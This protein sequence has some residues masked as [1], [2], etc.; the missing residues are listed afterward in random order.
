VA[1]ACYHG[2][3]Y[4]RRRVGGDIQQIINRCD[5]YREYIVRLGSSGNPKCCSSNSTD[6]APVLGC[7]DYFVFR[8]TIVKAACRELQILVY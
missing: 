7:F 2:N 1:L 4:I 5:A 8:R 3:L 6:N